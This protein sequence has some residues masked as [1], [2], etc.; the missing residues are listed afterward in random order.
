MAVA[1][2]AVA[3]EGVEDRRGATA[4]LRVCGADACVNDVGAHARPS[5]VVGVLAVER[6]VALVYAVESPRRAA[7]R[8][9][10]VHHSV[11]LDERDARVF[12]ERGGLLL[13]HL[14]GV[15]VQCV[16]VEPLDMAAV[17]G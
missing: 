9:R 7:L 13:S 11:L 10:G 2:L 15:A 6:K 3:A 1:I 5:P 16:L 12:A 8:G 14:G 17:G 4:E